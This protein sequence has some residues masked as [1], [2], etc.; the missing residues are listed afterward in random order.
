MSTNK[1]SILFFNMLLTTHPNI[2]IVFF[3][4]LMYKFFILIHLLYSCTCFNHY[5]AHLQEDNWISIASGTITFFR[6]LFSIQVAREFVHQV[7]KKSYHQISFVTHS[8]CVQCTHTNSYASE[9]DYHHYI[10]Q[11]CFVSNKFT[12]IIPVE[13]KQQTLFPHI[14]PTYHIFLL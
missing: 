8:Y 6:W 13:N 3:T 14:Q 7:G 1:P 10:I 9:R 12:S 11:S 4:N 2:M 5:Y